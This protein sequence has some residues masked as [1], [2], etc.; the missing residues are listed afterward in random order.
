[1]WPPN[2]QMSRS[3]ERF[4]QDAI[5]VVLDQIDDLIPALPSQYRAFAYLIRSIAIDP[6]YALSLDVKFIEDLWARHGFV[7]ATRLL[8]S[9]PPSDV[10]PYLLVTE[11]RG[12]RLQT[13]R[14]NHVATDEQPRQVFL[15][16]KARP[17]TVV[18]ANA[19][20]ARASKRN[21]SPLTI[22]PA[23]IRETVLQASLPNETGTCTPIGIDA[24]SK[25]P[26]DV[27]NANRGD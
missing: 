14:R 15:D 13:L 26:E 20:F 17:I 7:H 18:M 11:I 25:E 21:R 19:A 23:L 3:E 5:Q 2:T 9:V 8:S 10:A 16:Y 4:S 27:A 22:T 12:R 24:Q 1:M 6:E